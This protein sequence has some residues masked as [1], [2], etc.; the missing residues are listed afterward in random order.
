MG[1]YLK[2]LRAGRDFAV[3]DPFAGQMANFVYLIG[4][5]DTRECFVVDPAWDIDGIVGFVDREG[6][7]LEGALVT[8]YHPDHVGGQIFGHSISG[9]AD[10]LATRPVKVHVNNEERE[11]I[12]IVTGLSQ[13]DLVGHSGGDRLSIGSIEITLLHTPGHTPGSQ[14]F[15]LESAVISGDTLFIGGC[16][17][18][19]LPGGDPKQMYHSLTHVLAKLPDQILLMP[20][21][22][23]ASRPVSTI[24]DEKKGN[25]YLKMGS[26]GD[27]LKLM[28]GS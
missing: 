1:L 23:Y 17:R 5:D 7:K 20:G 27:W 10:L 4:D 18:V 22:D 25:Y 26:L 2:Q 6:M 9:L 21:H 3:N 19:D 15:L 8:H 14:C 13:S 12:A 16:G 11:G 28:G 24:G